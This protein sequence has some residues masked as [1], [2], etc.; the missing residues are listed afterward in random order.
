MLTN[1]D[2]NSRFLGKERLGMTIGQHLAIT[3]N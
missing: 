3:N 2:E 1:A